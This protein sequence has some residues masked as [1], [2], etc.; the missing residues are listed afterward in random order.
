MDQ[1]AHRG[2]RIPLRQT[3]DFCQPVSKAGQRLITTSA[4]R[5]TQSHIKAGGKHAFIARHRPFTQLFQRRRANLSLRR[6]NDPQKRAVIIR[7]SQYAQISQQVLDFRTGEERRATRYFVRDAVLHQ[8]F[9][10]YPRLMVAAIKN[11]V[12]FVLRFIDEV[13]RDQLAGD[14]L[15]FMFLVIRA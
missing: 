7:V 15:G 6:V 11:G 5:L 9:F 13:M 1:I 2:N 3:L 4:K 14:A 10:K 8:E 12:I